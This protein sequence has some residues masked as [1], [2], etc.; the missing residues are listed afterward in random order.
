MA[1]DDR[2]IQII[3]KEKTVPKVFI[4]Y[5][6]KDQEV[7]RKIEKKLKDAGIEV[8]IDY[9]AMSTGEN[10]TEFI[11]KCI[12]QT[13]ITL[14][15]VSSNSLM[16]AWVSME[17]IWSNYDETLR[18]RFFIPC[19]IDDAFLN[20][21]FVSKAHLVVKEDIKLIDKEI[22]YRLRNGIGIEDI[23]EGRTRLNRLKSELTSIVG[24]LKN[25]FCMNLCDANFDSGIEIVINDIKNSVYSKA[26]NGDLIKISD[27]KVNQQ[28]LKQNKTDRLT[29]QLQMVYVK[30]GIFTMGSPEGEVNRR[31]DETQ[32]QVKLSD[33]WL[34]KYAVTVADFKKFVDEKNYLTDAEK[35]DGSY[36]WNGKEW[37][38]EKGINWR[39]GVSG[40]LRDL[41]EYDHPVLHV[42]WNDSIA[43]C[44]WL[45]AKT[46]KTFRLPTEAEWE[47]ACR[48]GTTTPFNTGDNLTTEQANYDGNYPYNN[49]KKG[50]FRETTVP[51]GHFDPNSWGL[52]NMHGNVWEWC[53]DW[54]GEKYYDECKAKGTVENPEGPQNGSN[55]VVRGG[56]WINNALR[57]RTADRGDD[58]PGYRNN[59]IGFRLV[60]VP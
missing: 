27:E 30:G 4:S 21:S 31:N 12:K 28:G 51:V 50:I 59:S 39:F 22:R 14:S 5:N 32:H 7:A 41:A 49:N 47:F 20:I 34:G 11:Q 18:D 33:F 56:S 1:S 19:Y 26:E 54:Y 57:C 29:E 45:S 8:F 16:S 43:F 44:K 40:K 55:R 42:S 13:G 24:R 52:Y 35:G 17:T 53:N 60:F 25:T 15:V 3:E 38:Q 2:N 6:H 48:A 58:S 9:K 37:K 23:Q 10:I 46:G 36:I